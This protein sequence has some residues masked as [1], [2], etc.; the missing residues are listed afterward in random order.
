MSEH[1]QISEPED[2]P[3]RG[4]GLRI[5]LWIFG[6]LVLLIGGAAVAGTYYVKHLLTPPAAQTAAVRVTIPAGA[7]TAKIAAILENRGL[8][9][10]HTAFVYYIK[11][12]GEGSRFQAGEYE[13]TPG[14]TIG[15]IVDKLNAGDT[16][17]KETVRFTIPEGFTVPQIAAKLGE[18]GIANAATFLQLAD[19]PKT[20]PGSLWLADVPADKS[21]THRLEGYLFPETYEMVKGSS[22]AD[23]LQ[24]MI[25][26]WE[27]KTEALPPDWRSQMDKLGLDFHKLLTVASL[28]EREVV[29]DKERPIV[30]GVIYNRLKL[31][32]PLQI[33]ATVQY[34]LGET[35]ERLLEKDLQIK[36]PYN[37]YLNA[38]LPP[39]PIS[40]VG[41][42]SVRAAL[43]PE[44]TKYLYYVTKK[45][46]TQ[47]HL[48]AETL[49]QHN[50]N[51]A[52][53]KQT[54]K[55]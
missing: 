18:L 4:R 54:A 36:S 8:I 2:E 14:M 16:V 3:R 48:F 21:L 23:I 28:I 33:D 53:S 11:S 10:N 9:R 45:D 47:T 26:E 1:L 7:S 30:A 41:I 24:R 22:E 31:K 39:G 44:D 46:G 51:I 19:D 38:G 42:A 6:V 49:D 5:F 15:Q 50:R 13:M 37:T 43:Y 12:I 52:A 27:R 35:K 55:P 25:E 17:K 40:N 34:A 29:V 20:L 32:M